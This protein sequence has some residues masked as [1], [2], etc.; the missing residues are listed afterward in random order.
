MVKLG[1]RVMNQNITTWLV[2]QISSVPRWLLSIAGLVLLCGGL[3]IAAFV[4]R[5]ELAVATTFATTLLGTGILSLNLPKL[6]AG[7]I[8]DEREKGRL[9]EE[10]LKAERAEREAQEKLRE[11]D[12]EI[13]RLE[14]MQLSLQSFKPIANLGL[15]TVEMVIKDFR[16]KKLGPKEQKSV[17]GIPLGR[18]KQTSYMGAVEVPVKAHL[19]VDLHQVQIKVDAAGRLIVGGL[20]MSTTS[21]TVRGAEWQ[22]QE[23]RTEKFRNDE[24]SEIIIDPHDARLMA[25]RDAHERQLRERISVGQSFTVFEKPLLQATR[26]VLTSL[27]T[28]LGREIVY[29]DSPPSDATPLMNFLAGE[30][31]ALA[32]RIEER[33]RAIGPP[34]S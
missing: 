14:R 12:L 34:R 13:E 24:I 18:V 5:K 25:E 10:K 15:L 6:F 28:P 2:R 7:L 21:D 27:L 32:N 26:E 31:Q 29:V 19:G 1:N 9:L 4:E 33:R 20:T 22:L 3:I 30:Q 8:D 17:L 23:V 11:A 16:S